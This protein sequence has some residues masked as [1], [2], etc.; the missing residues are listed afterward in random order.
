MLGCQLIRA[1]GAC[2]IRRDRSERAPTS[3][4]HT[5]EGISSVFVARSVPEMSKVMEFVPVFDSTTGVEDVGGNVGCVAF[6]NSRVKPPFGAGDNCS[7][8]I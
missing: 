5:D 3:H 4:I 8:Q 6:M 2:M 1:T 7:F